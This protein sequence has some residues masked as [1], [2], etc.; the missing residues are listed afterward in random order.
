MSKSFFGGDTSVSHFTVDKR[1]VYPHEK[2]DPSKPS[3]ERI[4]I[5]RK[6]KQR[7]SDQYKTLKALGFKQ[8][9]FQYRNGDEEGKAKAKTKAEEFARVWSAKAGFELEVA[10]GFFL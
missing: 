1:Y 10:E 2:F 8:P 7:R 9:Y 4:A 3:Q 6:A 5:E